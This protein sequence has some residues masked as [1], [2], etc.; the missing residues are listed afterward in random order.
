MARLPT[1]PFLDN[2]LANP[3][4]N[5][6]RGSVCCIQLFQAEEPYVAVGVPSDEFV[7]GDERTAISNAI[8]RKCGGHCSGRGTM[9][10]HVGAINPPEHVANQF[11]NLAGIRRRSLTGHLHKLRAYLRCL[12]TISVHF[13]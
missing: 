8:A 6:A 2:F 5:Y 9:K 7:F 1:A 13:L 12:F 4:R 10:R 11:G 3:V